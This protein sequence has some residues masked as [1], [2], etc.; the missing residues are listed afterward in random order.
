MLKKLFKF[1]QWIFYKPFLIWWLRKER[2][3]VYSGLK[4]TVFPGVFHP[5]YFYSSRFLF[6]YIS[7]IEL[8]GKKVLELGAGSGLIS[9]FCAS[10]S[11][12]V[13]A[14]DVNPVAVKNIL[15]NSSRNAVKVKVIHSDLF[16]NI[17]V[18]IFDI[19]IINPPYYS[20]D[21][22][23]DA[24]YAWYCGKNMEYFT[25]LFSGLHPYVNSDSFVL[26]VLSEDCNLDRILKIANEQGF[27]FFLEKQKKICLEN[28]YLYSVKKTL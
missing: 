2:H 7:Q 14:T 23:S 5:R 10:Q 27:T 25:R 12:D 1:I 3:W 4:I 22:V 20:K 21:P 13:T 11:A 28:N 6:D 17:S 15:E 19:I 9:V 26:I 8:C 16:E 18:E 24:D